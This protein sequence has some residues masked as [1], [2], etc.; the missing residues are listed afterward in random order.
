MLRDPGFDVLRALRGAYKSLHVLA[1]ED[2]ARFCRANE[3]CF[4][5]D[6]RIHALLEGRREVYLR[7]MDYIDLP[8]DEH[9]ARLVEI[10]A[11]KLEDDE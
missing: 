2:L 3:T 10:R 7:I 5:A 8:I 6:P 11:T 9:Y 1:R 4:D